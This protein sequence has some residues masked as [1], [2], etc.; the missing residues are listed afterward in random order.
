MARRADLQIRLNGL[1]VTSALSIGLALVPTEPGGDRHPPGAGK[2][3]FGTTTSPLKNEDRTREFGFEQ[4]QRTTGSSIL[5]DWE[6][7]DKRAERDSLR[8]GE[9]RTDARMCPKPEAQMLVGVAVDLK[10]FRIGKVCRIAIGSIQHLEHRIALADSDAAEHPILRDKAGLRATGLSYRTTSSTAER[11]SERSSTNRCQCWRSPS[12]ST[13]PFPI[14]D[15][16]VSC[17]ATSK[18]RQV[19]IISGSDRPCGSDSEMTNVLSKSV[20]GCSRRSQKEPS[21]VVADLDDRALGSQEKLQRGFVDTLE[22]Q[23]PI[24]PSV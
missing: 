21:Q 24:R 20:P 2:V 23:N 19:L 22:A 3:K 10:R 12:I 17:P 6:A 16:V 14:S 18:V 11:T 15:L 8:R 13:R 1:P 9:W 7:L 4:S 5:N